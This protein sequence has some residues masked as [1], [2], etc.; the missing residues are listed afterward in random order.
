MPK[1]CFKNSKSEGMMKI[2]KELTGLGSTPI[3]ISELSVVNPLGVFEVDLII[4]QVYDTSIQ[5][6][7]NKFPC[8]WCEIYGSMANFV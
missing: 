4:E 5:V 6:I 2:S 1:G 7:K 3:H 8:S